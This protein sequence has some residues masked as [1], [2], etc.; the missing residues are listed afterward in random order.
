MSVEEKEQESRYASIMAF[1]AAYRDQWVKWFG[2]DTL[3]VIKPFLTKI[4]E[5]VMSLKPYDLISLNVLAEG[6][7][8]NFKAEAS[9]YVNQQAQM[10]RKLEIPDVDRRQTG[11]QSFSWTNGKP[12]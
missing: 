11:K 3:D 12:D 9:K 5:G 1:K 2:D 4:E 7:D 6:M 8:E 10:G